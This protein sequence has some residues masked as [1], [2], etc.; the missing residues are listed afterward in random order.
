MICTVHY[1]IY[2]CMIVAGV[3]I[4]GVIKN[5]LYNCPERN[6][7]Y[8]LGGE[9]YRFTVSFYTHM[10]V[11]VYFFGE[12]LLYNGMFRHLEPF[13]VHLHLILSV[14]H[15]PNAPTCPN[16]QIQATSSPTFHRRHPYL[17][18]RERISL[19]KKQQQVTLFWCDSSCENT[20]TVRVVQAASPT[21]DLVTGGPNPLLTQIVCSL[22]WAGVQHAITRSLYLGPVNLHSFAKQH[23]AR[24]LWHVATQQDTVGQHKLHNHELRNYGNAECVMSD[25]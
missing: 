17:G 5:L 1:G 9:F 3:Y 20:W 24:I 19:M 21:L 10:K 16:Y 18:H 25:H 7:G 2:C 13:W 11:T 15:L 22:G 6:W 14:A 8:S 12:T 23:A 4:W